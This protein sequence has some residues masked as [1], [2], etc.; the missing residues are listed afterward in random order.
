[1]GGGTTTSSPVLFETFDQN[2]NRTLK[3]SFPNQAAADAYLKA[4]Y[5]LSPTGSVG[6]NGTYNIFASDSSILE[7]G[8]IIL[9][10]N[11]SQVGNVGGTP[12]P[13]PPT[14]YLTQQQQNYYANP[15]IGQ[16]PLGP[17]VLPFT[18]VSQTFPTQAAALAFVNSQTVGQWTA[19][20]SG[21]GTYTVTR[22]G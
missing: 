2:G 10:V 6:S 3:M 4:N 17:Q 7:Y 22:T 14:P 8:Y 15:T 18:P 5:V 9:A 21:G 16:G 1:V 12:A 20:P 19:V 13:S 11:A